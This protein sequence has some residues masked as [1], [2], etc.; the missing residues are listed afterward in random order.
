MNP[1]LSGLYAITDE[2]LIEA[3]HFADAV[4]KALAG[5]ARILQ[6]RNKSGDAAVR[7]QQAKTLRTLCDQHQA[8]LIINDDVA[9]ARDCSADGVHLGQDDATI[10]AA[11]EVLGDTSIIGVSCYNRFE[12]A[13]T[14]SQ[15]GADYIAFGAFFASPTKPHAATADTGLLQRARDE[16]DVPVCAIGGITSANAAP[17]IAAGAN[18]LATISDVFGA[19]D[20]RQAAAQYELLF[21]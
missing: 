13:Q 7:L 11:R 18:M 14:A 21:R 6:Y 2:H 4:G 12:L 9:L 10:A 16:L 17:L 5:G 3:S 1:A 8:L 19:A 20:I 15:Q